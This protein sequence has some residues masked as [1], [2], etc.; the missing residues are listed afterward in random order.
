MTTIL[1][2]G[3]SAEGAKAIWELSDGD[4]LY[5]VRALVRSANG[6]YS[7]KSFSTEVSASKQGII[8]N[9]GCPSPSTTGLGPASVGNFLKKYEPTTLSQAIAY[10]KAL[11]PAMTFDHV[12]GLWSGGTHSNFQAWLAHAGFRPDA[13][14]GNI[15]ISDTEQV[16][17]LNFNDLGFGRRM[18]MR[19]D[20]NGNVYSFVTNFGCGNQDL[21]DANSAQ[22][23]DAVK[24]GATVAMEYSQ[25]NQ[26]VG[27]SAGLPF[28]GDANTSKV[29]KF[30]IFDTKGS[31][32]ITTYNPLAA[33]LLNA[34]DLDGNGNKFV[35]NLCVT[36]HGGK[37]LEPVTNFGEV[38][39]T[40]LPAILDRLTFPDATITAAQASL[41]ADSNTPQTG[42]NF[43]EFDLASFRYPAIVPTN[44]TTHVPTN[45]NVVK[46]FNL[47]NNFV[48]HTNPTPAISQ[49]I[50]GWQPGW[51]PG[52]N[53]IFNDAFV[54]TDWTD[55]PT[56]YKDVITKSCR[57]CHVALGNNSPVDFTKYSEFASY[58]NDIASKVYHL[59]TDNQ[60]PHS[61]ISYL[62]FWRP[63]VSPAITPA[64]VL[65][66]FSEPCLWGNSIAPSGISSFCGTPYIPIE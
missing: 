8:L 63:V 15:D 35:P 7:V 51:L 25:L 43:R 65:R 29:V 30:F 13:P 41:R 24:L 9:L 47:L 37:K 5:K 42:S 21:N 32:I 49:L 22:N 66:N 18:T 23:N 56:L 2:Q 62:N 60:M 1:T 39:T 38:S 19:K 14:L 16:S 64:E 10:Y 28:T 45:M 54:P 33:K 50:N 61:L 17:Y 34:A 55:Q 36:C 26:S 53:G 3:A 20:S 27:I 59:S 48:L 58:R 31:N 52:S 12:T 46:Q 6:L 44:A 4:K 11:D 40:D 57:T